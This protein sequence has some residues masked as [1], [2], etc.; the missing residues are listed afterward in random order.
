MEDQ[1]FEEIQRKYCSNSRSGKSRKPSRM[2]NRLVRNVSE[3][4]PYFLE[5][6]GKDAPILDIGCGDGLGLEVFKENGFTDVTGVEVVQER[7][8]TAQSYDLKVLQGTAETVKDVLKDT[9]KKYNIFCSHTLEHCQD[10]PLALSQIKDLALSLVWIL[11]PVEFKKKSGNVA[12]FTPID[13]LEQL[14]AFFDPMEW[15]NV[16]YMYR[17]NLEAEGLLAFVRK[18]IQS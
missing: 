14:R 7:V 18:T 4:L 11:V 2:G 17:N 12:H 15:K 5:N 1:K 13:S 10:Q 6:G 16:R 8:E 3:A 9:G